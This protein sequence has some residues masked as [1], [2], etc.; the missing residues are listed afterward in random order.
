MSL[1]DFGTSAGIYT[2][3]DPPN[4]AKSNVYLHIWLE[5]SLEGSVENRGKQSFQLNSG[6]GLDLLH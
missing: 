2:T 3:K 6:L 1:A 4:W 5:L